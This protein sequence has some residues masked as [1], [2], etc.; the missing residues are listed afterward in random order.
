MR[1][2]GLMGLHPPEWINA[3]LAGVS[4]FLWENVSYHE[5]VGYETNTAS[6][7]VLCS[8]KIL[9]APSPQQS[10]DTV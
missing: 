5:R 1:C 2:L 3:N 6:S 8:H 10:F 9:T 7:A 4:Y